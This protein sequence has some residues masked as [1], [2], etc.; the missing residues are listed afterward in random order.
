M[1]VA[2]QMIIRS[3]G[4]GPCTASYLPRLVLVKLVGEILQIIHNAIN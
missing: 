3:V 4:P 1:S 2:L